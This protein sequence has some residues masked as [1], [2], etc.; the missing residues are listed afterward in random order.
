M[1]PR[2]TQAQIEAYN[3]RIAAI[4][5][6]GTS[7]AIASASTVPQ[8]PAKATKYG[9][10]R[11]KSM[12]KTERAFLDILEAR[13][14][15]GDF[16][17]VDREALKFKIGERCYFSPDFIA[18]AMDGTVTAFEVKGGFIVDEGGI[19]KFKAA[20]EKY[21]WCR[22]ELWQFKSGTWSQIR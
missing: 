5:R 2:F 12:N 20:R 14:R 9:L 8:Q 3:A 7:K 4:R 10:G 16:Q 15:K 1:T 6:F 17:T 18:V 11:S 21:P 22:F 19:I 13:R